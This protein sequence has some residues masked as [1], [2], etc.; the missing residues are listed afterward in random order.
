MTAT[1]KKTPILFATLLTLATPA[2]A[3]DWWTIP[4]GLRF[5]TDEVC[6]LFK[7][8]VEC[9]DADGNF[10]AS[11][12]G[13]TEG[14]RNPTL[15]QRHLA[16]IAADSRL[17][18]KRL[19]NFRHFV[20]DYIKRPPVNKN[21]GEL[22]LDLKQVGGMWAFVATFKSDDRQG[23]TMDT[24]FVETWYDGRIIKIVV[25]SADTDA[26]VRAVYSSLQTLEPDIH[27]YS[28]ADTFQN[29]WR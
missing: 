18:A 1:F 10:L 7:Q 25:N 11:Y 23:A 2:F 5:G 8:N 28:E 15:S 24:V 22:Q 6:T 4:G 3:G 13:G 27:A 9:V 26:A 29:T 14:S 21:L 19:A 12:S 17:T 16:D 20:L